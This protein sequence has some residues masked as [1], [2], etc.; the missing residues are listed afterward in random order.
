MSKKDDIGKRL[1][2][3]NNADK[4][5]CRDWGTKHGQQGGMG[6][7]LNLEERER[8][9]AAADKMR[10]LTMVFQFIAFIGRAVSKQEVLAKFP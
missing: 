2:A 10:Y 4:T 1:A 5:A 3:K 8:N 7:Y 6:G 9:Q